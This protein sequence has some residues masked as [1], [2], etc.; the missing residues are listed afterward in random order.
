MTSTPL[1]DN[2]PIC[3][4]L[5]E[6]KNIIYKNQGA[7]RKEKQEAINGIETALKLIGCPKHR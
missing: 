4:A 5:E 6:A 1:F 2:Q 7:P 3:D